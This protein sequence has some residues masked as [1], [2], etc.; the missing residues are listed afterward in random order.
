[1]SLTSLDK[2]TDENVRHQE[3]VSLLREI[4]LNIVFLTTQME[5]AFKLGINQEDIDYGDN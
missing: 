2:D 5:E 3:L 4:N 1:M